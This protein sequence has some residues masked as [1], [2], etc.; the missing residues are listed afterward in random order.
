MNLRR[1]SPID[2]DGFQ[3]LIARFESIQAWASCWSLLARR[4]RRC[5]GQPERAAAQ[6]R[7]HQPLKEANGQHDL[8][9]FVLQSASDPWIDNYDWRRIKT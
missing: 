3:L 9:Q 7:Q 1:S 5:G 4:L 2:S 8:H 6:N